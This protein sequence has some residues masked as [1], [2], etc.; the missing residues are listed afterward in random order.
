MSV[1]EGE[2]VCGIGADVDNVEQIAHK[3]CHTECGCVCGVGEC[4][5]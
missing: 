3:L 5:G 2:C 4:V 1:C